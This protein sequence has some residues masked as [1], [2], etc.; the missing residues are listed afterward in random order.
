MIFRRQKNIERIVDILRF[1]AFLKIKLG[2]FPSEVEI[3]DM[4]NRREKL[5][6]RR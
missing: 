2:K 3:V 6:N 5:G 1:L 4:E